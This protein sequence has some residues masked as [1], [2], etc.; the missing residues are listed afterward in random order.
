MAS[1]S[2][3][4]LSETAKI[5]M[6]DVGSAFLGYSFAAIPL[7]AK[8]ERAADNASSLLLPLIAVS[9]VW[10]FLFDTILTFFRRFFNGEK[11]WQAHRGHIYQRLVIAGY[12][13]RFVSAL[14]G[15]ASVLTIIFLIY[16]LQPKGNSIGGLIFLL[17]FQAFGILGILYFSK[18]KSDL[19]K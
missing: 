13:H 19:I 4:Y 7:L 18:P 16:A 11:V 1:P 2:R 9:L 5:F 14:Y 12:T 8:N 17:V 6:G 15:T 3:T 10:L